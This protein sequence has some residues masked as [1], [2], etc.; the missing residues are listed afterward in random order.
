M[1]LSLR[2]VP[3]KADIAAYLILFCFTIVFA[4]YAFSYH[5]TFFSE[6]THSLEI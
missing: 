4:A 3:M 5:T 6:I 1:S 2:Y